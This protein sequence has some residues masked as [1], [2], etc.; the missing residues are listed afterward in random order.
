LF[1]ILSNPGK[2]E[3]QRFKWLLVALT[4]WF[5][6]EFTYSFYQIVLNIDAPYPG[7][8]E[9][10][11]LA[12]YAPLILFTYRSFKNIKREGKIKRKVIL[13]VVTPVFVL[14]VT[15]S[16]LFLARTLIFNPSGLKLCLI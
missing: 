1:T 15:L 5:L 3:V 13:F 2:K 14:P 6:G 11:Y 4:L 12:G 8:G 10:F 16:I 9:I 7:V